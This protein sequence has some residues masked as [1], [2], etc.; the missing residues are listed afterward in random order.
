MAARDN[1]VASGDTPPPGVVSLTSPRLPPSRRDEGAN[2]LRD[3]GMK[4]MMGAHP[5]TSTASPGIRKADGPQH[6]PGAPALKNTVYAGAVRHLLAV[7]EK[8]GL[9]PRRLLVEA[10]AGGCDLADPDQRVSMDCYVALW[11]IAAPRFS[12]GALGLVLGGD[13]QLDDGNLLTYIAAH[14]ATLH[15]AA[16]RA[17]RYRHL[18]HELMVPTI[19]GEGEIAYLRQCLPPAVVRC[20]AFAEGI[21]AT[22]ARTFSLYL[23]TSW[24]PQ[25][26]WLQTAAPRALRPYDEAFRCR[27]RFSQ[28][29]SRVIASRGAFDERPR[30]ANPRLRV[31]LEQQARVEI[32]RLPREDRLAAQVRR[33]L[34]G[35]LRGGDPSLERIAACLTLS[36]RTLQR[37]LKEE[38]VF[39]ND[40]LDELRRELC[41]QYLQDPSLSIGEIAFL[42]GYAERGGF[43]RAFRRWTGRAPQALRAGVTSSEPACSLAG[44]TSPRAAGSL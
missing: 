16:S 9:D 39:F 8:A 20:G 35:E 10:G 43:H 38:G 2:A 34:V 26:V 11:R 28:P 5:I 41:E 18:V 13:F 27:V 1:G 4:G 12:G 40:L 19:E 15:E 32:E 30:L 37:R 7:L 36:P 33:L 17:Q 25:E 3:G 14:S 22:W 6:R 42:L 29:E 31:Y 44:A 21:V 24:W 23:G